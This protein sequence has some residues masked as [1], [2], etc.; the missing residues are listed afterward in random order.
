[1][2]YNLFLSNG[3]RKRPLRDILHTN[4]KKERV[5][6][7]EKLTYCNKLLF[8]AC[9]MVSTLAVHSVLG[10]VRTEHGPTIVF[11]FLQIYY[12]NRYNIIMALIITVIQHV[13]FQN[14]I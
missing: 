13:K 9:A 4:L 7:L 8:F 1:M 10:F 2:L 11:P 12:Y 3:N 6:L 14:L 5:K